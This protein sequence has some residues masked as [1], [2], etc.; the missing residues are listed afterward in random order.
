MYFAG[1]GPLTWPLFWT[2]S[3][4]DARSNDENKPEPPLSLVPCSELGKAEDEDDE[5]VLAIN[6]TI[7]SSSDVLQRVE[8]A[9][10]N[11]SSLRAIT[12]AREDPSPQRAG[13]GY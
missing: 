13:I 8:A 9:R 1:V 7:V 2:I 3:S 12:S 10:Q 6:K 5:R 11:I 4:A